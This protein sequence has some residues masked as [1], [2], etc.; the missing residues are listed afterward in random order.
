VDG[1]RPTAGALRNTGALGVALCGLAQDNRRVSEKGAEMAAA[2][3]REKVQRILTKN[4]G[5]VEVDQDGDFLIREGS[6]AV[7]VRVTDWLDDTLVFLVVPM[8]HGVPATPELFRWVATDGQGFLFGNSRAYEKGD[9]TVDL[10]LEH[11]L[12]GTY[13]D[14]SELMVALIGVAGTANHFDDEL[15]NRFGGKR[16][17]DS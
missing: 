16:L 15:Q 8:L 4:L 11:T 7:V 2:E 10:T 1:L 3:V 17:F 6:T 13:L 5:S 9:G 12:L 14:E